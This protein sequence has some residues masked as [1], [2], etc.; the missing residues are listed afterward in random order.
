ML[1]R[2]PTRLSMALTMLC[3]S[4]CTFGQQNFVKSSF[5]QDSINFMS[6]PSGYRMAGTLSYPV[7][8]RKCPAVILVWG[9]GPH[10]R[11][12]VV[13][14]FPAFQIIADYFNHA[15]YVVLRIDKRGFIYG[16][17][18][19][20]VTPDTN[21]LPLLDAIKQSGNKHVSITILPGLDHFF[22]VKSLLDGRCQIMTSHV[23]PG[24][25]P[26]EETDRRLQRFAIN[27]LAAI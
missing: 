3:C 13:S 6:Q 20:E 4:L 17:E 21:L 10:T 12:E 7:K 27:W 2:C 15:G 26:D 14:K 22:E 11:D 9:T 16:G 1:Y 24:D 18:D 23:V 8:D 25:E 19:E 5:R